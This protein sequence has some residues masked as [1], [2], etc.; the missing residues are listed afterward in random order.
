MQKGYYW[1]KVRM[2]VWYTRSDSQAS[3]RKVFIANY[4]PNL[5]FCSL[6]RDYWTVLHSGGKNL[7]QIFAI[8]KTPTGSGHGQMSCLLVMTHQIETIWWSHTD[9]LCTEKGYK[10]KKSHIKWDDITSV[11]KEHLVHPGLWWGDCC[12]Q[13][14]LS[15]RYKYN[16][17]SIICSDDGCG[18]LN[19]ISVA[20]R[21]TTELQSHLMRQILVA[22]NVI[23]GRK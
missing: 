11:F 21:D 15:V 9:G 3:W 19:S 17:K 5:N 1:P 18:S 16:S 14:W 20:C 23:Y 2:T 10:E 12:C 13:I 6:R 7:S 8:P 22:S 4:C